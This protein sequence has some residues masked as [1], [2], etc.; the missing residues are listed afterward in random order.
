MVLGM[1]VFPVSAA[2][3]EVVE[4]V[5]LPGGAVDVGVDFGGEDAFVAEHL[6]DG[7]QVGA[8]FDEVGGEGVAE[9]VRGNLL[10][11]AGLNGV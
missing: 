1:S 10:A 9:S 6:L 8:V 7:T 5:A 3:R 2:L 11:D 4:D